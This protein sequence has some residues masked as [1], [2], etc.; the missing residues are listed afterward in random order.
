MVLWSNVRL[1]LLPF[2]FVLFRLLKWVGWFVYE[3]ASKS[4]FYQQFRARVRPAEVW[5]RQRLEVIV[6]P[7]IRATLF[8]ILKGDSKV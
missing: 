7:P 3:S 6:P 8:I 4:D 5:L 2:I 1:I